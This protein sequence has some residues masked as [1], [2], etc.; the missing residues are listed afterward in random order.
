MNYFASVSARF[1]FFNGK[2]GFTVEYCYGLSKW[3]I[4]NEHETQNCIHIKFDKR[5]RPSKVNC[6]TASSVLYQY[7]ESLKK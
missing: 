6:D 5:L 4:F 7:I 2:T 3:F 1:F